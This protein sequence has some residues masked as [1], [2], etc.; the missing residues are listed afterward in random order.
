M[1][2]A[3]HLFVYGS[4]APGEKNHHLMAP[5]RGQWCRAETQGKLVRIV[6]GVDRG[7]FGLLAGENR[8][9]GWVMTS[10]QLRH[11]WSRLDD[12]EGGNYERRLCR[13]KVRTKQLDAYA[14]FLRDPDLASNGPS[15]L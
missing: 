10:Y 2:G 3:Q 13:V 11:H 5:L 12:F 14:Y 15:R 4:L 8:I 6:R 1:Q 9:E 7:Y